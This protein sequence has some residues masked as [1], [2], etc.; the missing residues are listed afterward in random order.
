MK[1]ILAALSASVFLAACGGGSGS[2]SGTGETGT[3]NLSVTDA[4]VDDADNVFVTFTGVELRREGA[5]PI[6]I[7]FDE[8]VREDLLAFQGQ[9]SFFIVQD[10]PIPAGVYD[11][12]RLFVDGPGNAACNVG[13]PPYASSIVIDGDERPLI[14]PS[15]VQ[16]GL[17][18]K[19]GITIAAGATGNYVIDFDLRKSIAERGVTGC[20]NLRPVLHVMDLAETGS[21]TGSVDPGLLA[22]MSC[23]SDADSGA[24]AAVYVYEGAG[25]TPDDFDG[26]EPGTEGDVGPDPLV[27]ALLTRVPAEGVLENFSYEVGFLLAGDYTVAFTCQAGDDVPPNEDGIE[28][29]NALSFVQPQNATIVA[30]QAT[31]VNFTFT[32]PVTEEP[33]TE[34]PVPAE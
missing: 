16:T 22:D 9:N 5:D 25:Q 28:S 6:R 10:E 32:A 30:D 12:V 18:L 7:D 23:T 15:G 11:E 29:D 1:K 3:L 27:T 26:L 20:Y 33:V 31:E 24:G 4:P 2:G 34:D 21:L 13:T 19:G 14:V 17:K 8:P